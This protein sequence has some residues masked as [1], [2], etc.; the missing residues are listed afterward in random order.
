[1]KLLR[2]TV[3]VP[4]VVVLAACTAI[5]P[6]TSTVPSVDVE[7]YLG[8]WYEVGSIKQFFSVGL[9][10]TTAQYSLLPDGSIRVENSGNYFSPDGLESRIVG[11][12]VPVDSTN[13]RLNVSFTGANGADPPGNYWIVDL[14]PDYRWAIVSDPTGLSGFLLSRTRTVTPELYDELVDR[15]AAKGVEVANLTPTPQY[16]PA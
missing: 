9:V 11:T 4:L 13:A 14:D 15:A 1:M 6:R 16:P 2:A 5:P 10:N 8:T 3:L 7:R 12:A